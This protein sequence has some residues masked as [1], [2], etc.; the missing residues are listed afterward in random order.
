MAWAGLALRRISSGMSLL[1]TSEST[2]VFRVK[3]SDL[4]GYSRVN[5]SCAEPKK[6]TYH[7]S[8]RYLVVSE[9]GLDLFSNHEDRFFPRDTRVLAMLII[10]VA[11]GDGR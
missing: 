2:S 1:V 4:L 10:N 6:R 5:R 7:L 9:N 11:E 8:V 3:Y